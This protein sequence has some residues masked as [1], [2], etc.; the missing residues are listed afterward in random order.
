MLVL[1]A[2]SSGYNQSGD[3]WILYEYK[4]TR[5]PSRKNTSKAPPQWL[6][7]AFTYLHVFL[8]RLSGGLNTLAGKETCFI[9]MTGAR[10]NRTREIP[11]LYIPHG[12]RILLVASAGGAPNHPAWYHNLVKYPNIEV[13]HQGERREFRA[14]LTLGDEKDKF[15]PICYRHYA[16]YAE[17]RKRTTRDIPIFICEPSIYE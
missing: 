5:S 4:M 6:L 11:L 7:K 8:H 3:A 10:S 13:E 9:T 15:W 12:K 1:A 17:Y 16:P 2:L 14:R